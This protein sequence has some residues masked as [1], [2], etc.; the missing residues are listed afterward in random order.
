VEF[1]IADDDVWLSAFGAA[2]QTE[3]ASGDD[4]V[5]EVRVPLSATEELH[6]TWDVIHQSVPFRYARAA[7]VVV[8]IFRERA[9]LL[10]VDDN[11]AGTVVIL[12]YHADDCHG[13][14]QVR[15]RPTF[16]LK[17]TFLQT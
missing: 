12:E 5:R 17:D 11:E 1:V 13:Q 3:E 14:A 4:F 2:P 8:D 16:A 9:T 7:E 10:T 6:V 15:T